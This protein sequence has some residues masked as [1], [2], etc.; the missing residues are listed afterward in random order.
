M[1]LREFVN[2]YFTEAKKQEKKKQAKKKP[3]KKEEGEEKTDK[4]FTKFNSKMSDEPIDRTKCY[5]CGK[6]IKETDEDI[7][8]DTSGKLYH[9]PCFEKLSGN[10]ELNTNKYNEK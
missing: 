4:K 5:G 6:K 1:T 10:E 3:A 8:S 2:G 9:K 7:E